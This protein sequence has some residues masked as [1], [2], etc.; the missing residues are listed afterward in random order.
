MQSRNCLEKIPNP[1]G[2]QKLLCSGLCSCQM[3]GTS[4]L[5]AKRRLPGLCFS[6]STLKLQKTS[7]GIFWKHNETV[8]VQF[9]WIPLH[10]SHKTIMCITMTEQYSVSR[11]KENSPQLYFPFPQWSHVPWKLMNLGLGNKF[12]TVLKKLLY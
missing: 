1:F 3:K 8:S 5:P 12:G 9:L 4:V 11:K 10:N 2:N 7:C 6:C